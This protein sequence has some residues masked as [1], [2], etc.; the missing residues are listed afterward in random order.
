MHFKLNPSPYHPQ[1]PKFYGNPDANGAILTDERIQAFAVIRAFGSQGQKQSQYVADFFNGVKDQF[2][3]WATY[4]QGG[5][6]QLV[7]IGQHFDLPSTALQA[8]ENGTANV[9]VEFQTG[10]KSA[11]GLSADGT[12]LLGVMA[13]QATTVSIGAVGSEYSAVCDAFQRDLNAGAHGGDK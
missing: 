5:T 1:L 10:L 6:A 4:P 2:G 12:P 7:D 3:N 8:V 11:Q 13:C 9:R